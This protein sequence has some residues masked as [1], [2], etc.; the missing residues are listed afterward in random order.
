MTRSSSLAMRQ[1]F[2]E[3]R[4]IKHVKEYGL[5]SFARKYK[6]RLLDTRLDECYKNGTL[7]NI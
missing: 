1:Y 6:K 3:P 5:L 7:Q 2:I 4:T